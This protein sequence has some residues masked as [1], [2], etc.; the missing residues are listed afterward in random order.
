MRS[1]ATLIRPYIDNREILGAALAILHGGEITYVGGFGETSIEEGGTHVTPG[2]LFA[3]GSICKT[4]CATLIM[5]LVEQELLALD[6]PIRHYLPTLAFSNAAYGAKLTLRHV[7]SHTSGL[8]MAGKSWGPRH[9]ESLGQFVYEHIPHYTFVAEPGILHLYSNTVFC[10]AGHL[11]EVV[12]GKFYDDVVQEYVF[13]PL[14]MTRTTFDPAVALTYPVALPHASDGDG[15]LCTI[16]RMAYNVSGNPSNFALGS[17]TDLA[18]LAS[19]YLNH[20]HF[21]AQPYLSVASITAMH[22]VYG[23]RCI[24]GAAHPFAYTY[25]GYGLGFMVGQYKGR[26]IAR[27]GGVTQSYRSFFDLFPEEQVGV[28]LLTNYSQESGGS[29]HTLRDRVV[30][31]C[32]GCAQSWP[33]V[34]Q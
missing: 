20:G 1:L 7:L 8:P 18:H 13:D 21:G 26:R 34:P 6:T 29:A 14:Q 28:V 10:I 31:S 15:V 27:H 16:H 9:P 33:G 5:R 2:T 4:I 19:M 23:S 3:F 30:R 25:E 12:T 11:A 22:Q 24:A 17:V 32:L